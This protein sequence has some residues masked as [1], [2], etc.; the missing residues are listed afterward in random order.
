MPRVIL[1]AVIIG[2]LLAGFSSC[3]TAPEEASEVAMGARGERESEAVPEDG[4]SRPRQPEADADRAPQEGEPAAPER[5]DRKT[6]RAVMRR[7]IDLLPSGHRP[8]TAREGGDPITAEI[9]LNQ[10]GVQEVCLFTV[11]DGDGSRSLE[12]LSDI[13]RTVDEEALSAAFG[14]EIFD[15]A[16]GRPT[17]LRDVAAGTSP[18]LRDVGVRR[19]N[20]DDRLPIAFY[21]DFAD[22]KGQQLVWVVHGGGARV[23]TLVLRKDA[24]FGTEVKDIDDDGILDVLRSE[25]HLEDGTGYE[26]FI[27][28]IRWNGRTYSEY[29][30]TNIVRN[31]NEYLATAGRILGASDLSVFAEKALSER[32]LERLRA[33]GLDDLMIVNKILRPSSSSLQS[34]RELL[35]R[36]GE[37]EAA[38]FPRFFE[39]P[40]SDPGATLTTPVRI[41]C[42]GGLSA[43]FETRLAMAENPFSSPQFFFIPGSR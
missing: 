21:F 23:S 9:D 15:V 29:R 16:D 39:N 7:I 14:V 2:L 25:R 40:F 35:R 20:Q 8:L 31:L 34:F 10:D 33:E 4:G 28:W 41:V 12:V 11:R 27:T 37:V 32:T 6:E 13:S 1:G 22:S 17:L 43:V 18:V 3:A 36:D 42:C 38:E 5:S 30:T 19:L 26:T 24:L